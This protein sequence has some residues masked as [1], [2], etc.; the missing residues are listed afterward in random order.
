M[1]NRH[2]N[3]N[4]P[5]AFAERI[6]NKHEQDDMGHAHHEV[7]KPTD[8]SV[9]LRAAKRRSCSQNHCDNRRH[10]CGDQTQHDARRKARKRAREHVTPHPIGAER[11]SKARSKRLQR[12]IGRGRRI[13][14]VRGG[15]QRR[16]RGQEVRTILLGYGDAVLA[17]D[18]FV[19]R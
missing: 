17:E 15:R 12:E 14:K 4:A 18:L 1:R 5:K 10:A 8:H 3:S 7:D 9:D 11:M 6:G 13:G 16:E 19:I 2:A